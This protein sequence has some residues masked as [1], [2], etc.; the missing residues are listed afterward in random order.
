MKSS[1]N[2]KKTTVRNR[3]KPPENC[4]F[5]TETGGLGTGTGTVTAKHPRGSVLVQ[6]FLKPESAVPNRN[7]R[8]LNRGHLYLRPPLGVPFH[9]GTSFK[10]YLKKWVKKISG[11]EVSLVYITLK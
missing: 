2:R 6:Q 10:K 1:W 8:F 3:K 9:G 5:G 4:R 11:M 7:R